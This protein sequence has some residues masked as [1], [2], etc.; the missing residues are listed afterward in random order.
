[1]FRVKDKSYCKI[2]FYLI[3][4]LFLSA[5]EGAAQQRVQFTQYMYDG[6][7]LNPAYAGADEALS[8]TFITRDQ[9]SGL[10]GAPNSQ[11]L[12]GH[13]L[14]KKKNVGVG[15]TINNEQIGVH[16]NLNV[17]TSYAYHLNLDETSFLSFGLQAGINNLR[18][19]YGSILGEAGNDPLLN[20]ALI[21]HTSF[22]FGAGI[23]YK[24]EKLD[25]GYSAPEMIPEKFPLNDTFSVKLNNLNH[26]I[27]SK[28]RLSVNEHIDMT[29]SILLKY[30]SG[31]PL[32]FDMNIN[33]IYRD[34]LTTG[35]SYRRNESI[36][37]LLKIK[38]TPQ[39]QVGYS[40]DYPIKQIAE[41]T[42]ASH[43]LMIQY[44]F[45]FTQK[46]VASPR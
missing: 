18:S 46:N 17:S 1:M 27:F 24:S 23:Y 41:L 12:T 14:F 6:L 2:S 11:T 21:T 32:S 38:A 3:L 31:V 5:L 39:L 35:L 42:S 34:V 44:L 4:L 19:D 28:Y 37:F 20:N 40:Y 9:W 29:P 7:V 16:R 43:E 22:N 33:F 45:S 15:L 25:I 30:M 26:F 13:T 10:K 8:L 36:D